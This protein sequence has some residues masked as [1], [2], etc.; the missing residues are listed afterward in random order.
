MV[1]RFELKGGQAAI[2]H[3]A[4]EQAALPAPGKKAKPKISFDE[5]DF[6][7]Y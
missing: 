3:R 7:K 5:S 6:G 4:A 2:G 1:G